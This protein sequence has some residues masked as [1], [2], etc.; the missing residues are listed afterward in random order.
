MNNNTIHLNEWQKY[1]QE[2]HFKLFLEL[3]G[4]TEE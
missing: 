4:M 2:E 3:H 1:L